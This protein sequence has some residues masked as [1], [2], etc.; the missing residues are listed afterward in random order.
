MVSIV[1]PT[2]NRKD[3]LRKALASI[4]QQTLLPNEVLIVDSSDE[5]AYHEDILRRFER[6]RIT[7]ILSEAS[8]CVQRNKGIQAA[9]GN[10]IL[11]LDDDIEIEVR[12]LE[13]LVCYCELNPQ[14]GAV[15][16]RL[17]QLEGGMWVDQYPPPSYRS[18]LF[19]FVF[20]LPVWG[21]VSYE[22]LF[23]SKMFL[24]KAMANFYR[25]KGNTFSRAGWPLITNWSQSFTTSIY[26]LGADLVKR[27]WL[28][29][30]P[31]DE[32]LDRNG[33]GDNY[34]VAIG[35]PGSCPIH[36]LSEVR[37]FHYRANENR[38]QKQKAYVNRLYALH[39]FIGR[40]D[41]FNEATIRWF[42][43]S[44]IGNAFFFMTKADFSQMSSTI[45]ALTRMV[46]GRN[47]YHRKRKEYVT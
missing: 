38:L 8:V 31:Y 36:V 29:E 13:K 10:W 1:I 42:Y 4:E 28:I 35:F 26:S 17:M 16:G 15:A 39:Y 34:G 33:I 9:E 46:L 23:Q 30:S 40:S 44:L 47:P 20:Q 32:L 37:A 25:I 3:H 45:K 27:D 5:V 19:K 24:S 14:C 21:D 43:W 22:K 7:F 12:Y 11:L 18:L 2:R 6:L 41:K